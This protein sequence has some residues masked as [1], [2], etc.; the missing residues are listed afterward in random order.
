MTNH[1]ALFKS[2][3][4]TS[5]KNL[6]SEPANGMRANWELEKTQLASFAYQISRLVDV[7][8]SV[9]VDYI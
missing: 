9:V 1:I 6:K 2:S 3:D 8:Y 5:H 4:Q 7:L